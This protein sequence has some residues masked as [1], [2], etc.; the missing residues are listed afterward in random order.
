MRRLAAV[1]VVLVSV[2]TGGFAALNAQDKPVILLDTSGNGG[3]TYAWNGSTTEMAEILKADGFELRQANLVSLKDE[4]LAGVDILLL[5]GPRVMSVEKKEVIIR[6]IQNGGGVFV[7]V[8]PGYGDATNIN[9]LIANFGLTFDEFWSSATIANLVA[10]TILAQPFPVGQIGTD[11]S[12]HFTIAVTP[13]QGEAVALEQNGKIWVARSTS[14]NLKLGRLMAIGYDYLMTD[15]R[16]KDQPGNANFARNVMQYLKGSQADLSVS[17]VKAKGKGFVA[18]GNVT[19]IIKGKNLSQAASPATKVTITLVDVDQINGGPGD[20]IKT[21]GSGDL[22]SVK[23]SGKYKISKTVKIPG[24]L[25]PGEYYL[26]VVVDPDE[27]TGD[28]NRANN[29]GASKKIVIQ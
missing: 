2:I 16:Y 26:I 4:D 14:P 8:Y 12:F 7:A 29:T 19:V 18:G 23:P 28:P 13:G 11:E 1:F 3:G 15:F 5:L 27:K 21:L 17:R 22:G 10:G 9:S 24:N 6:F 25:D 20:A